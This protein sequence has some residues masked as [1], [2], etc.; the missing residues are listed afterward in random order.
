VSD[1]VDALVD[2]GLAGLRRRMGKV[3]AG[4][5]GVTLAA[6][7]AIPFTTAIAPTAL[8]LWIGTGL[9]ARRWW[10]RHARYDKR[11]RAE[12]RDHPRG[13]VEIAHRPSGFVGFR[14]S[15]GSQGILHFGPGR[16]GAVVQLL[17]A[18]CPD[19]WVHEGMLAR[20]WKRQPTARLLPPK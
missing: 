11:L 1:D 18:R 2:E 16:V 9:T 15:D 6:T 4:I 13:I 17:T 5:L 3:G 19:A 10:T 14:L 7:L 20:D 12:L 8:G